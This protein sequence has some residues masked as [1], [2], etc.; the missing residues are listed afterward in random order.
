MRFRVFAFSVA[1]GSLLACDHNPAAP[2]S[3]PAMSAA[4]AQ[5]AS[6]SPAATSA[7]SSGRGRENVL[8]NMSDACDPDSFNAIIG[9]GTCVRNG[10]MPFERFTT[11]LQQL[12]FVGPW[13]F[14]PNNANVVVGQTFVAE[15]MGGEVH[16][17]TEVSEFGGGIVPILNQL[18]GFGAPAHEC[19]TLEDDDFVPPGG[20]YTEKVDH[21]GSVKFQCCIHP[22][23]RLEATAK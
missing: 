13:H 11:L 15:N 22:W 16:T 20:T 9:P 2:T 8:V 12:G 10:G 4:A 14:A 18:G 23:M 1:L 21:T 5:S 3:G 17:F 19:T 6:A 7:A